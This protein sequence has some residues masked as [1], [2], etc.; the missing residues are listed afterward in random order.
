MR[1]LLRDQIAQRVVG[2]DRAEALDVRADRLKLG[3]G[4]I[5]T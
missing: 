1:P 3:V 4:Q 2:V 5:A